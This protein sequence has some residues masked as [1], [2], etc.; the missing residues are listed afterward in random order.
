METRI[1]LENKK[2]EGGCLTSLALN[3]C[4]VTSNLMLDHS[5]IACLHR[6]SQPQSHEP[7]MLYTKVSPPPVQSAIN[8]GR[9]ARGSHCNEIK[10]NQPQFP[11]FYWALFQF[12]SCISI[13][14]RMI[15]SVAAACWVHVGTLCENNVK[16]LCVCMLCPHFEPL[17]GTTHLPKMC[18]W[19]WQNKRDAVTKPPNSGIPHFAPWLFRM[20]P[21]CCHQQK[22]DTYPHCTSVVQ[23]HCW[24]WMCQKAYWHSYCGCTACTTAHARR[25]ASG[26]MQSGRCPFCLDMLLILTVYIL[27]VCWTTS[28]MPALRLH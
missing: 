20:T 24:T 8:R 10:P 9:E 18:S 12:L 19:W 21:V 1:S 3:V 7:V 26:N 14:I 16:Y 2:T 5:A 22:S 6:H 4:F 17:Q 15:L 23:Q 11:V 13:Y 25:K 28:P 27:R